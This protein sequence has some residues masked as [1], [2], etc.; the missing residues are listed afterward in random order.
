M[1]KYIDFSS[2]VLTKRTSDFGTGF[3]SCGSAP[4]NTEELVTQHGI[5]TCLSP[6]FQTIG[7]FLML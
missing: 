7:F 2:Y 4:G 6:V 5:P 3:V 1:R